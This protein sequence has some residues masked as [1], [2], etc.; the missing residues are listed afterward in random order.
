MGS[1]PLSA[2]AVLLSF[3]LAACLRILRVSVHRLPSQDWL[4]VHIEPESEADLQ[5][6][7]L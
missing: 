5:V 4:V 6:S 7:T 3:I 2:R 1:I